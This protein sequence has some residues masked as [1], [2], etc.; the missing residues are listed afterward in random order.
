MN[1]SALCLTISFTIPA[2]LREYFSK[3]G[4][5]QSCVLKTD[6]ETG[7]SRGF[8]FVVFSDPSSVDKV[9]QFS[10]SLLTLI[11]QSTFNSTSVN[12][13]QWQIV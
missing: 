10:H 2:S 7:R 9:R 1:G 11:F 3:Y 5:I 12:M 4:E 13:A 6:Q 8:G